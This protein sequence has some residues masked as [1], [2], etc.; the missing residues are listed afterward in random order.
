MAETTSV[1]DTRTLFLSEEVVLDGVQELHESLRAVADLDD[2][3]IDASDARFIDSA[4]WQLLLAFFQKNK[5]A[6]MVNAPEGVHGQ[7]RTLG[8]DRLIPLGEPAS[9][10]SEP[11]AEDDLCPVF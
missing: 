8:F 11:E 7:A 6:R 10:K 9:E 3:I 2:V 4:G 5:S 1:A